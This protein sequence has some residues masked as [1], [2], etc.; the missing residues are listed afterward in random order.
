LIIN[1]DPIGDEVSPMKV[2]DVAKHFFDEVE[3]NIPD[4]P[5]FAQAVRWCW[6]RTTSE[7]IFHLE[8]D[9]TLSKQ[10][11]MNKLIS[12]MNN[13]QDMVGLRFPKDRLYKVDNNS[14]KKGFIKNNKLLLNPM[15]YRGSFIRGIAS[16]MGIKDNPERQL[17][18]KYKL[19]KDKY[20]GIYCG[21]GVGEYISHI[22]R[23][24][25]RQSNYHK[26]KG[27][28]FITWDKIN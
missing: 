5:N 9:W 28:N 17:R 21:A 8:D 26:R 3:F 23:K 4:E 15:L 7:F 14:T 10:I 24:W 16:K 22:G 13:N 27:S 6:G 20:V 19:S 18:R 1:I 2:V 11:N 25:Q 12:L